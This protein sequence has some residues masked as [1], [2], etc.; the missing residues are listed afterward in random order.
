MIHTQ[1]ASKRYL[2]SSYDES[3]GTLLLVTVFMVAIFG[4]AALSVDVGYV[5]TNRKKVHEACDAAAL[6]AV[7]DW[8]MGKTPAEVEALGRAFAIQNDV[9][10]EEILAVETGIWVDDS[11]TF[12]GPL[13][14]L[15]PNSVPAV[16]V[17]GRRT[18]QLAFGQVVG[19]SEMRPLVESIAITGASSAA[20]RVLPWAVC[21]SFVP[22]E[23]L[24]IT[25]QFKDDGA[26]NACS[27]TGGLSGNFGQLTLPGGSGASW[28]RNN[29]AE[30]YNGVLRIGDCFPTD[31]GV[32][33]GPTRQGINDRIGGLPQ[34][35]CSPGTIPQNKRLGIVP[36]VS[37]LDVSGKKQTCITGFYVI[38]LDG[39]NNSAKTVTATFLNVYGGSEVDPRVPP[40][41]GLLWTSALVK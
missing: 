34:F 19:I 37:T 33:W 23:C 9:A 6:A 17:V 31:P 24:T 41:P 21:D 16:R 26:E 5:L 40:S 22:T 1:R 3:G 11:K 18:V 7:V 30:G 35:N 36:R 28:Y 2:R 32:S 10:D 25:L 15:P 8:T 29:I 14:T 20:G 38:S 12:V 39:Y 4:F 27:S 13:S